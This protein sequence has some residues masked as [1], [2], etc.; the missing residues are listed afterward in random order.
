[1]F[2]WLI[3]HLWLRNL[4]FGNNCSQL[5]STII[6]EIEHPNILVFSSYSKVKKLQIVE[7]ILEVRAIDERLKLVH[8]YLT[9]CKLLSMCPFFFRILSPGC[10]HSLPNFFKQSTKNSV[11][12]TKPFYSVLTPPFTS[13]NGY[14]K[15]LAET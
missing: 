2:I 6:S 1:M 9:N 12:S 10:P 7:L 11:L 14:M 4:S 5:R 13:E 3:S 8:S 15:F